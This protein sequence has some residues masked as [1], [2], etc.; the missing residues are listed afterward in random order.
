M[1]IKNNLYF[2]NVSRRWKKETEVS[3]KVIFLSP[4]ITSSTAETVLLSN[5]GT[6]CTVYTC[7]DAESF[8]CKASSLATLKK[9][10]RK[11]CSLFSV[12]SLHAKVML[13]E[14]FISVGSQNLTNKGASSREATFCSDE[15]RF[16]SYGY[17]AVSAW[18]EDAE[19]ITLEMIEDMEELI[20]PYV[21]EFEKLKRSVENIE[22]LLAA[23]SKQR[24]NIVLK[25][26]LSAMRRNARALESSSFI[27]AS[28]EHLTNYGEWNDTYTYSLVPSD[29]L[30]S[31]CHWTIGIAEV[32]LSTQNRYLLI[33]M[34][35]AKIGWARIGKTRI[36]YICDSVFRKEAVWLGKRAVQVGFCANWSPTITEYNLTVTL[37]YEQSAI[38]LVYRCSF[39]LEFISK[40]TLDENTSSEGASNSEEH[41]WNISYTDEF[42]NCIVK[43]LLSP[44]LYEQKLVG[45]QANEFFKNTK[46]YWKKVSLAKFRGHNLLVS[47]PDT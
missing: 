11:G 18:T 16:I 3:N 15:E 30:H 21:T 14:D 37:T 24:K 28:V 45:E 8:V 36:T 42:E 25:E 23:N 47:E 31:F 7:F 38:T 46:S 12:E 33:D 29:S 4:Y 44:F 32:M 26:R 39:D 27:Y 13:T 19:E 41:R 5:I 6:N 35:T 22:T 34:E 43:Q 2:R 1:N 10:L 9:L 20:A 40:I 17:E